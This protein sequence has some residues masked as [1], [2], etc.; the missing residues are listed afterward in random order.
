[1]KLSVKCNTR[2]YGYKLYHGLRGCYPR[3]ISSAKKPIDFEP[4]PTYE[5]RQTFSHDY[6]RYQ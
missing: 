2:V 4:R 5:P 6:M 3:W 1:M